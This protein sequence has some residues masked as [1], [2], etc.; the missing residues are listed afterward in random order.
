MLDGARR[1]LTQRQQIKDHKVCEVLERNG[2]S[3]EGARDIDHWI[4]FENPEARDAFSA[5][6]ALMDFQIRC[7][8]DGKTGFGRY[9]I[10]LYRLDVPSIAGI[11]SVT[12]PLYRLA[13]EFGGEYDGWETEVLKGSD[14]SV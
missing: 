4:Y 8:V 10:Q 14:S 13:R 11:N 7:L 9:G 3:L 5:Q 1:T 12:I 6:A 2:D